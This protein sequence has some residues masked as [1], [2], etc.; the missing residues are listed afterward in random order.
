MITTVQ[1][2]P[3]IDH[4]AVWV[5][6]LFVTLSMEMGNTDYSH[7]KMPKMC[8]QYTHVNA[9]VN[10]DVSSEISDFCPVAFCI[11]SLRRI[12][13]LVSTSKA[14]LNALIWRGMGDAHPDNTRDGTDSSQPSPLI[15]CHSVCSSEC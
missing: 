9:T 14:D 3:C 2:R 1:L 10:G 6:K 11:A 5:H 8:L 12:S 15:A 7:I 13:H 4:Y